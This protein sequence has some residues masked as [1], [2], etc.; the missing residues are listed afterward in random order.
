MKD[1]MQTLT[2]WV[3]D[4]SSRRWA[5]GRSLLPGLLLTFTIAAAAFELRNL[6]GIA[7]LSP[8]IIAIVL[9]MGFHNT[10]GTPSTFKPGVFNE[11]T[12]IDGAAHKD[13]EAVADGV[14]FVRDVI[15]KT[16]QLMALDGGSFTEVYPGTATVRTREQI[17]QFIRNEAWGH[18][19]CGTSKIGADDDPT[20]VLDSRFRVRG[21][22]RLRVVD[23]SVFP[24]IPG[25]FI[26]VPIYMLSE[27]AADV[28][29]EDLE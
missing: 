28:I 14:E 11:G 20:A 13:L 1:E 17:K 3:P 9:G 26:A 15:A 8:L 5:S 29:L 10:V 16:I 19:A 18:H 21:T 25:F 12:T 4:R 24:R 2:I 27:K 7:A 22:R 6:S 23:A